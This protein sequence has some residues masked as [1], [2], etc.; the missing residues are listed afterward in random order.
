[1][2]NSRLLTYSSEVITPFHLL[3][4]RNIAAAQEMNLIRRDVNTGDLTNRV[5]YIRLLLNHFW[6]RFYNEYTVALRERMM[7]DE[8]K[9]SSDKLATGDAV[10][11]KNNTTTR[12]SK[13]KHGRVKSL[14]KG[15]DNIVRGAVLTSSTNGKLIGISLPLQKLIPL[16]VCDNLNVELAYE[17]EQIVISG[18][19]K[20]NAA[21]TGELVRRTAVMK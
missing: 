7:Y 19:P 12:R 2:I 15:R 21:R 3:H 5:K 8:T 1:M 4:C 13:W 17:K 18:R 20:Q 10:M 16:E 6:K 11:I 9:H 14:I